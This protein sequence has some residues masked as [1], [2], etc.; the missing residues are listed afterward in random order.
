MAFYSNLNNFWK[1]GAELFSRKHLSYDIMRWPN[2]EEELKQWSK[3]WYWVF[4]CFIH[5]R[6]DYF[7]VIQHV[8]LQNHKFFHWASD[9]CQNILDEKGKS[10]FEDFPVFSSWDLWKKS[11]KFEL[12]SLHPFFQP[13]NFRV[14][15]FPLLRIQL[16]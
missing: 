12:S 13:S 5:M 2:R 7:A 14:I 9:C 11:C 3:K 10:G 15:P 4:M 6:I 8:S 1:R 16:S